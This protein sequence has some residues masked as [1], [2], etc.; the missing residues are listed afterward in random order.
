MITRLKIEGLFGNPKFNYDLVFKDRV[1]IL[2]GPNG[3]GKS[4]VLRILEALGS[5][6]VYF[7]TDLVFLSVVVWFDN[8]DVVEIKNYDKYIMFGGFE[9][10]KVRYYGLIDWEKTI[11]HTVSKNEIMHTPINQVDYRLIQKGRAFVEGKFIEETIESFC[12]K[13]AAL[14]GNIVVISEQRLID[15]N[16]GKD[17][18]QTATEVVT[19]KPKE[20]KQEID[21]V[22]S[23]FAKKASEEDAKLPKR[24]NKGERITEEQYKEFQKQLNDRFDKL[25]IYNLTNEPT[26]SEPYQESTSA[27]MNAFFRTNINKYTVYDALLNKLDLFVGIVNNRLMFK[28]LEISGENGFEVIDTETKNPLALEQLSSGEKQVIVMYYSLIFNNENLLL[29]IDEPEISMHIVWQKQFMDDLIKIAEHGDF[30]AIVATHSPYVI[31]NHWESQI[32]LGEQYQDE[33]YGEDVGE[34]YGD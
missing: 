28:Y 9:I 25:R 8:D 17:G 29:L 2:T 24:I 15:I 32:D 13:I 7:F 26:Q 3:F 1:T 31:G 22:R 20:M 5:G 33:L 30:R 12:K 23:A 6:N 27:S 11:D 21:N 16:T 34:S 10:P 19:K 14:C 4:T 18:N